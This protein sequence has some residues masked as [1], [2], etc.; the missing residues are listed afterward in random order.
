MLELQHLE[1][2]IDRDP[3]RWGPAAHSAGEAADHLLVPVQQPSARQQRPRTQHPEPVGTGAGSTRA[4][5]I[6]RTVAAIVR[7]LHQYVTKDV[8]GGK[9]L[10]AHHTQVPFGKRRLEV[11]VQGCRNALAIKLRTDH[12]WGG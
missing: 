5:N 7:D 9:T 8:D 4:K 1:S 11:H 12:C 2:V 10:L 3:W 6:H